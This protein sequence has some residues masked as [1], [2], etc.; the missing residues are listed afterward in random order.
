MAPLVGDFAAARLAQRTT[1]PLRQLLSGCFYFPPPRSPCVG[2]DSFKRILRPR[3]L[4]FV[5][6]YTHDL[7]PFRLL[8]FEYV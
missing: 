7:T 5:A 2:H 1:E 6:Q 4:L 8:N 3:A